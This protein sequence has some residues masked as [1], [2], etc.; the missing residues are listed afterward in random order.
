MRAH[1]TVCVLLAVV[2]VATA[3]WGDDWREVRTKSEN[4]VLFVESIR[5]K[6]DGTGAPTVSTGT[7]FIIS[8]DG[9]VITAAHVVLD[10]LPDTSV[11]TTARVRSRHTSTTYDLMF[12]KK[13]PDFDVAVLLLP[14]LGPWKYLPFGDSTS[15]PKDT[16]LYTL[17]FPGA[18]DLASAEGL[19]SSKRGPRGH[20]QTTLPLNYGNSGGPVLE[21]TGKVVAIAS[22]GNDAQQGVTF[23]VPE[24]HARGIWKVAGAE[25]RTQGAAIATAVA[26][27]VGGKDK[28][29]TIYGIHETATVSLGA[30]MTGRE[31]PALQTTSW[32]RYPDTQR[33]EIRIPRDA[34]DNAYS[35]IAVTHVV[36]PRGA[37]TTGMMGST[38]LSTREREDGLADLRTDLF[39]V[40]KNINSDT[41]TFEAR[42]TTKIGDATAY[43]LFVNAQ[44]T[45][46]KWYVDKTTGRLLRSVRVDAN[47]GATVTDYG[48]WK[49]FEGFLYPTIAIFSRDGVKAGEMTVQSLDVNPT[50]APALFEKPRMGNLPKN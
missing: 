12:L 36:S 29:K 15:V 9:Y 46:L 42:G 7:G 32:K 22:G 34:N 14:D 18:L 5:T 43:V 37:F 38:R 41:Y 6:H 49:P 21:K 31:I 8:P 20:W 48:G 19:L 23:A 25:L 28:I 30:P 13:D 1:N 26:S 40:L 33:V 17:G 24:A 2:V 11:R 47:K 10:E 39:A 50:F 45:R 35:D 44:G 27:F 3:A 4:A 16:R